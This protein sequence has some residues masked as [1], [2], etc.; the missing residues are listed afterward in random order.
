MNQDYPNLNLRMLDVG[1]RRGIDDSYRDLARLNH[2]YLEGIEPDAKECEAIL[3]H[4]FY[5]KV[6]PVAVAGRTGKSPLYITKVLGCTSI[7]KP[8]FK[9]LERYSLSP[10]FE[11]QDEIEIN[12]TT[13]DTLFNPEENF[14]FITM[15][16]QGA[17]YEILKAGDRLL[18]QVLCLTMEFHLLE[19]YEGQT[20]FPTTHQFMSA[21]GFRLIDFGCGDFDGE[22]AEG[23]CVYLRDYQRLASK[24]EVLKCILFAMIWNN[25]SYVENILRNAPERLL[26]PNERQHIR[27]LLGIKAKEKMVPGADGLTGYL[28]RDGSGYR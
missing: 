5:S 4:G 16:T 12:V 28:Y 22:M 26:S 18:S 11:V 15:D 9:N 20:L 8:N 2:F 23:H 1:A 14:D 13:L 3:S 27:Q 6:R 7:Y 21:K 25:K 19:L 24:D 10:W 17:E